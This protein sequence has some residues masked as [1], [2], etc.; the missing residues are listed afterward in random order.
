[1]EFLKKNWL[2]IALGIGF[3]LAFTEKGKALFA[4]GKAKLFR[5]IQ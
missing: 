4:D 2:Y 3:V 5:V 1:M